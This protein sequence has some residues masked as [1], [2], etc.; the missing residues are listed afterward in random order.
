MDAL[1]EKAGE[2][3]KPVFEKAHYNPETGRWEGT[4][5]AWDQVLGKEDKEKLVCGI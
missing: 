3:R 1:K 4:W 2:K 5:L